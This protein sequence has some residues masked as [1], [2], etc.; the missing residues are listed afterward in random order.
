MMLES[1]I[2]S[3]N[4]LLS[5][6]G[7]Q[8]WPLTQTEI[9]F[10]TGRKLLRAHPG[11][12]EESRAATRD[13]RPGVTGSRGFPWRAPGKGLT[14]SGL[15]LCKRLPHSCI[16]VVGKNTRTSSYSNICCLINDHG[17][18]IFLLVCKFLKFAILAYFNKDQKVVNW[19]T[20]VLGSN[21]CLQIIFGGHLITFN[22]THQYVKTLLVILKLKY[23][24]LSFEIQ[25]VA[26]GRRR[27]VWVSMLA[28]EPDLVPAL[29][30]T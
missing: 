11:S 18:F 22:N 10:H 15:W 26:P 2:F 12:L 3:L 25:V 1:F 21:P 23:P 30:Q 14:N 4:I 29:I 7:K 24:L 8:S 13:R 17:G 20:L 5:D 28:E 16:I 6:R 9:A 27:L 19:I